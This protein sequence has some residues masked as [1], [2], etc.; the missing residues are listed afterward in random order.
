MRWLVRHLWFQIWIKSSA[1][2]TTWSFKQIYVVKF[3]RQI[4]SYFVAQSTNKWIFLANLYEDMIVEAKW[5]IDATTKHHHFVTKNIELV[6]NV[7]AIVDKLWK[8]LRHHY[9]FYILYWND[10]E[11]SSTFVKFSLLDDNAYI[12]GHRIGHLK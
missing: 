1:F 7:H 9:E 4:F 6:Q 8:H 12:T 3:E 10:R 11:I 2:D 5:S